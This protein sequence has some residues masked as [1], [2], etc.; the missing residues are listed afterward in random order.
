MAGR[1]LPWLLLAWWAGVT[2]AREAG[3]IPPDWRS[4]LAMAAGLIGFGTTL[5]VRRLHMLQRQREWVESSGRA[6]NPLAGGRTGPRPGTPAQRL[7]ALEGGMEICEAT[8]ARCEERL[9]RVFDCLESVCESAGLPVGG[10]VTRPDL[11]CLP[12]GAVG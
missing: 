11:K 4:W 8:T 12:G 6:L 3:L 9:T 5:A 10:Q 2:V 1:I 7:E